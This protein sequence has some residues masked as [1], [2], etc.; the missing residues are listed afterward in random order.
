ML[1]TIAPVRVVGLCKRSYTLK[2]LKRSSSF[3][4]MWILARSPL[5]MEQVSWKERPPS[6]MTPGAQTHC[7]RDQLPK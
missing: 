1:A 4:V 5:F 7:R 2:E 6:E 3:Q